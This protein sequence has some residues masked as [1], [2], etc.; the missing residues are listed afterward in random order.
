MAGEIDRAAY[1]IGHAGR[2]RI[3]CRQLREIARQREI[4]VQGKRQRIKTGVCS[5]RP[6]GENPAIRRGGGRGDD[7]IALITPPW[8]VERNRPLTIGGECHSISGERKKVSGDS[9][10]GV[11]DDIQRI[12]RTIRV[13]RPVRKIPAG[14]WHG[15]D[16]DS[17]PRWIGAVRRI[18][19]HY[20]R[21][22][23]VDRE[24]IVGGIRS[25]GHK[26]KKEKREL[27]TNLEKSIFHKESN[28]CVA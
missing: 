15:G 27:N 4:C 5:A 13:T 1:G 12:H 28:C 19:G 20:A 21:T 6:T 8:W 24:C 25:A 23:G 11:H 9:Q 17:H 26:E 10:V 14:I 3:E 16:D 22:L 18:L 7:G 2:L